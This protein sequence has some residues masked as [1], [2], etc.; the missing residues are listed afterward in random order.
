MKPNYLF[1][2]LVKILCLILCVGSLLG[3]AY[4]G[5]R[6]IYMDENHVM[7]DNPSFS[8]YWITYSTTAELYWPR[9]VWGYISEDI[10]KPLTAEEDYIDYYDFYG[11]I[12]A[13]HMRNLIRNQVYAQMS[14][15]TYRFSDIPLIINGDNICPAEETAGLNSFLENFSGERSNFCF[16]FS[17]RSGTDETVFFSNTGAETEFSS[18]VIGNASGYYEIPLADTGYTLVFLYGLRQGLPYDDGYAVFYERWLSD[19]ASWEMWLLETAA[20]AVAS[21][22]LLVLVLYQSGMR[23]RTPGM[24][25]LSKT[26]RLPMGLTIGIKTGLI[27]LLLALIMES[28]HWVSDAAQIPRLLFGY[29]RNTALRVWLVPILMIVCAVVIC[30]FGLSILRE[31][32]RRFRGGYWW[33]H[34]FIWMIWRIIRRILK[35][36]AK[37]IAALFENLPVLWRWLVGCGLFGLLTLLAIAI[38]GRFAFVWFCIAAA[39][40]VLGCFWILQLDRVQHGAEKIASGDIAYQIGT[41]RMIGMPK[42]LANSLNKIGGATQI[43]VEERMKSER[44]RSELIT[45]VSHDLKTPL[46]SIINYTDLLSKEE[47]ENETM[48][49]YIE[50]LCRQSDRLKKMTDDLLEAAKASSGAI[51]VTLAPTDTAELLTQAAGEYEERFEKAGLHPVID[52]R[53]QP[54]MISADGR[55]LWRVFDN[56]LSNICKYSLPGTRVYLTAQKTGNHVLLLFR[57]ISKETISVN[58]DELT[59]RFVRG[60]SSRHTEGSGLGLAIADSLTALQ[61]GELQLTIDGDLFKAVLRFPCMEAHEK[62]E[63]DN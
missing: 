37:L 32:V 40:S 21:L 28:A 56:L 14:D 24:I 11:D 8:P 36:C 10:E 6:C 30:W 7:E 41:D 16:R 63:S 54:L 52:I 59:E 5:L 61:G 50:V 3:F 25:Y 15:K 38:P 33:H 62:P 9:Y 22:V 47:C 53:N 12:L 1:H 46:T 29:E 51:S 42:A 44:F 26:D 31:I 58:A 4:S 57:N 45:N 23:Y 48:K 19:C 34:T 39:L 49:G 55:H 13:Q 17:I 43:A 35:S 27:V 18:F 2:P 20:F 60:D